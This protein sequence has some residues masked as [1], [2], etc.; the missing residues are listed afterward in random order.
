M[1]PYWR[2]IEYRWLDGSTLPNLT[3]GVESVSDSRP[4][5]DWLDP[6]PTR[7]KIARRAQEL[8]FGRGAPP[9]P[10][11]QFW[12]EAEQQ[13]LSRAARIVLKSFAQRETRSISRDRNR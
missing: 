4:V 3:L 5:W 8:Y 10:R 11:T 12:F 7:E 1:W 9:G 6:F 2:L 13:L